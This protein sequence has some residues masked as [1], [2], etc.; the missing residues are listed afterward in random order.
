MEVAGALAR[1]HAL[2]DTEDVAVHTLARVLALALVEVTDAAVVP[3]RGLLGD[4]GHGLVL[5][6]VLLADLLRDAALV[7]VARASSDGVW[8]GGCFHSDSLTLRDKSKDVTK[9]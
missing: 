1:G 9:I 2:V 5:D 4:V 7:A 8:Q 6:L 3:T